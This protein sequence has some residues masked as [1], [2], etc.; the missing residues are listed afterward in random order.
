MSK[1]EEKIA[2]RSEMINPVAAQLLFS[3]LILGMH[4]MKQISLLF[5][6]LINEVE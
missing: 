2:V 1:W 6:R 4:M 3:L 5:S